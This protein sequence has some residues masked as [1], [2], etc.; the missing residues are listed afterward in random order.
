MI[1]RVSWRV[2]LLTAH[3]PLG[4]Q[5]EELAHSLSEDMQE[6]GLW[7]KTLTLKLKSTDF[8][9]PSPALRRCRVWTSQ[10]PAS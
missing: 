7:A 8:Q 3:A 6:K 1:E 2:R 5:C 9:V 10:P 4:S